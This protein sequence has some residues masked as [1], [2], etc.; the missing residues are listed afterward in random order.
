M[1]LKFGPILFFIHLVFHPLSFHDLSVANDML[2]KIY[3]FKQNLL[4]RVVIYFENQ[5][6]ILKQKAYLK[7]CIWSEVWYS[8]S[9]KIICWNNFGILVVKFSF[10][11]KIGNVV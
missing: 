2:E 8:V 10:W 9:G 4:L 6:A 7:I 3:P 11:V 1:P 5:N